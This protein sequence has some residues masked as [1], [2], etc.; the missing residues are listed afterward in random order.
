[1]VPDVEEVTMMLVST[2]GVLEAWQGAAVMS[3][4]DMYYYHTVED[5]QKW[6]IQELSTTQG[7]PQAKTP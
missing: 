5:Y 4:R 6:L 2:S 3:L 7:L 1:M